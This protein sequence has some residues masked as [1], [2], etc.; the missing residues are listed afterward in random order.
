MLHDLFAAALGKSP[1]V[2][3]EALFTLHYFAKLY[4][5]YLGARETG[6][7]KV[8]ERR[9]ADLYRYAFCHAT[10]DRRGPH[11]SETDALY[12][13][14]ELL[15]EG[16]GEAGA[17]DEARQPVLDQFGILEAAHQRS[18]ANALLS[19]GIPAQF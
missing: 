17:S 10:N 19:R 13:E 2:N 4:A 6:R 9:Y 3:R 15:D 11:K 16:A 14:L 8:A 12:A 5:E 1:A 18:C 7:A